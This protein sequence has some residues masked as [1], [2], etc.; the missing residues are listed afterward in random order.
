[1]KFYF[2]KRV[3]ALSFFSFIL[4]IGLTLFSPRERLCEVKYYGTPD[5]EKLPENIL[6]SQLSSYDMDYNYYKALNGTNCTESHGEFFCKLSKHIFYYGNKVREGTLDEYSA[7]YK[8]A[9]QV[10]KIYELYGLYELQ[11][12]LIPLHTNH[13]IADQ[14]LE[15]E[16]FR[17]IVNKFDNSYDTNYTSTMKVTNNMNYH[18]GDTI[19]CYVNNYIYCNSDQSCNIYLEKHFDF[20]GF[21]NFLRY[22]MRCSTMFVFSIFMIAISF[23]FYKFFIKNKNIKFY[24]D[25]SDSDSDSDS[26]NEDNETDNEDNES[27][28]EDNETDNE[29]NESDNEDNESDESDNDSENDLPNTVRISRSRSTSSEP[30]QPRLVDYD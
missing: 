28:N 3:A 13:I 20:D 12:K 23:R 11:L 16:A 27:D 22:V 7:H 29:D 5:L 17:Y 10:E 30:M 1:M 4:W 2:T 24:N 8:I 19:T 15:K 9:H 21:G 14:V 18:I 26:D 6:N 25:D